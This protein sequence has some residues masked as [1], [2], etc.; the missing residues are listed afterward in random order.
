M[1][2]TDLLVW[3]YC[4]TTAK[5]FNELNEIKNRPRREMIETGVCISFPLKIGCKY[6]KGTKY[7]RDTSIVI[8][9][10]LVCKLS[11]TSEMLEIIHDF[12][13]NW[14]TE[15]VFILEMTVTGFDEGDVFNLYN[16]Y[17]KTYFDVNNFLHLLIEQ[18]SHLKWQPKILVFDV[19]PINML[20]LWSTTRG[21]AN[22]VSL[23]AGSYFSDIFRSCLKTSHSCEGHLLYHLEE[24]RLNYH[25]LPFQIS[26]INLLKH[27][28]F[29][30]EEK[31]EL[32][33]NLGDETKKLCII[34]NNE[35][36]PH[37]LKKKYMTSKTVEN[38]EVALERHNFECRKFTNLKCSDMWETLSTLSEDESLKSYEA[39]VVILISISQTIK[40]KD[41][42]YGTDGEYITM[43]D[44]IVLF[45]DE[46]CESLKG[47]VKMLVIDGPRG[48]KIPANRSEEDQQGIKAIS[49]LFDT[50]VSHL[51]NMPNSFS[52]N[53]NTAFGNF[54]TGNCI[55]ISLY[56][57]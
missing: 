16:N 27:I 21:Y 7:P 33:H 38:Y 41:V 34:I 17:D 55:P 40:N 13:A 51:K 22:R 54:V 4:L 32:Y 5:M 2:N 46:Y 6:E 1:H 42:I 52:L 37:N 11:S 39:L 44:L 49:E 57:H 48:E 31:T 3:Y 56:D 35:N 53:V 36:F 26:T 8:R 29:G 47:K 50:S 18:N 28:T 10:S 20:I 30:R 45:S 23:I 25:Q 14:N 15:D 12:A 24:F 43:N 9:D 19:C